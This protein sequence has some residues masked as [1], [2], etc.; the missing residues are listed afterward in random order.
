[1]TRTQNQGLSAHKVM[2]QFRK[3]RSSL[4]F[5]GSIL[6]HLAGFTGRAWLAIKDGRMR[7]LLRCRRIMNGSEYTIISSSIS[8]ITLH[9]WLS[10][11]ASREW[12][13]VVRRPSGSLN[14]IRRSLPLLLHS[15]RMGGHQRKLASANAE[16]AADAAH[17]RV[18]ATNSAAVQVISCHA[19]AGTGGRIQGQWR[20]I[21]RGI[22][23]GGRG[24]AVCYGG[25][26]CSKGHSSRNRRAAPCR[27]SIWYGYTSFFGASIQA[28]G[29]VAVSAPYVNN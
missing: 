4:E 21:V 20:C 9:L 18:Q 12:A 26:L 29:L 2:K 14:Q 13:F 6:C 16:A 22:G 3:T 10:F 11:K 17:L 28:S 15:S 25:A 7:S 1:M 8:Q 5:L 24:Q 19:S 27:G 23:G